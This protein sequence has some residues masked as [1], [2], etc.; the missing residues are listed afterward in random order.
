MNGYYILKKYKLIIQFHIGL[1]TLHDIISVK[2]TLLNDRDFNPDYSLLICTEDI[3]LE[4]SENDIHAFIKHAYW[5]NQFKN[6]NI[7]IIA[8]DPK[9]VAF[10][11]I[12]QDFA[13]K[14]SANYRVFSTIDAGLLF[15]NTKY[16]QND[17][18]DINEQIKRLQAKTGS[19]LKSESSVE[20]KNTFQFNAMQYV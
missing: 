13:R 18:N 5:L 15:I 19:L 17:R 4:I 1:I 11:T 6:R 20:K 16:S 10:A 9:T 12:F 7:A 2:Q 14:Y 3:K 8:N